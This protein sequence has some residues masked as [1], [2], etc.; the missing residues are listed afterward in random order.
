MIRY[1]V[2][3]L[4]FAIVTLFAIA[5]VTFFLIFVAG[6]PAQSLLPAGENSPEQVAIVQR[7]F[8]FNQPLIVQFWKFLVAAVHGNFGVSINYGMPA[9]PLVLSRLPATLFLAS[10]AMALACVVAIPL[11]VWVAA[12]TNAARTNSAADRLLS[13]LSAGGL[14][15]P[16]FW[17]GTMLMFVFAIRLRALPASGY[18]TAAS[19]VMPV[20]TLAV[21]PAAVTYR[22]TRSA[23]IEEGNKEYL[24]MARAK[25]LRPGRILWRHQFRNS[26]ITIVTAVALQLGALI[27]G[28]VVTE[29][30]FAWPGVGQLAVSSVINR[31]VPVV[32]AVVLVVSGLYLLLNL[33]VDILYAL[34]NPG[35]RLG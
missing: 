10:A 21:A 35:V 1:L 6:D 17:L 16:T 23:M 12:R 24:I 11:G 7:T 9:M 29:S 3:R 13:A 2:R 27:G 15:I 14:A 22:F 28:A 30:V 19:A 33:C 25:G 34:I 8:G 18:G 31:D 20:L 4:I 32:M 5:C 26:L